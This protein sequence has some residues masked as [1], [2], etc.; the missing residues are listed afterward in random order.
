MSAYPGQGV[1]HAKIVV[2]LAGLSGGVLHLDHGRIHLGGE[3]RKAGD[4]F[5]VSC[6]GDW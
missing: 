4:T 1:V 5:R 6:S 3:C 2:P